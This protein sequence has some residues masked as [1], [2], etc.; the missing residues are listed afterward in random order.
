M[1]SLRSRLSNLW[2]MSEYEPR[3]LGTSPEPEAKV[4]QLIKK[5]TQ[6]GRFI[7]RTSPDPVK[8]LIEEN[9]HE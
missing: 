9:S 5:P 4:I 1:L 7:P 3:V 2:R 6:S 8:A